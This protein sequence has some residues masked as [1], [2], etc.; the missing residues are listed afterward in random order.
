MSPAQHDRI[1]RKAVL[2]PVSDNAADAMDGFM[3]AA[4]NDHDDVLEIFNQAQQMKGSHDPFLWTVLQNG[5][6]C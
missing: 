3:E 5:D 1:R 2:N 6:R 4:A